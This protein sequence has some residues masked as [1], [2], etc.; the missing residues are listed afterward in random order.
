VKN[1]C[2]G[3]DSPNVKF[4][5]NNL[6]YPYHSHC[7]NNRPTNKTSY[8]RHGYVYEVPNSIEQSPSSNDN[9]SLAAYRPI[10]VTHAQPQHQQSMWCRQQTDEDSF[11]TTIILSFRTPQHN[12]LN[13]IFIFHTVRKIQLVHHFRPHKW[14]CH[15]RR[16]HSRIR[17]VASSNHMKSRGT[18]C[19]YVLQLCNSWNLFNGSVGKTQ[20]TQKNAQH[21][22]LKGLLV[23]FVT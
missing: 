6:K 21:G 17:H 4:I 14:H 11:L 19:K 9:S 13:N 23:P 20:Q 16:T 3:T 8:I 1:T 2:K 18:A 5:G 15:S 7:F 10:I 22:V 12:F